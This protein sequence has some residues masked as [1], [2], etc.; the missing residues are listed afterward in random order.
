MTNIRELPSVEYLNECFSLNEE[1]GILY[2]K[3]RP[4]KHFNYDKSIYNNWN[5]RFPGKI[6]GSRQ[7]KIKEYRRIYIFHF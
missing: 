5:S 7:D 4:I 3:N 1:T 6:A 2:W